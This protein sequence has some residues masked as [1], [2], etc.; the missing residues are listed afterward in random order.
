MRFMMAAFLFLRLKQNVRSRKI[1]LKN[2]RRII[3][4]GLI[5]LI[6]PQPEIEPLSLLM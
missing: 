3:V 6:Q 2:A 4:A 5:C 1:L